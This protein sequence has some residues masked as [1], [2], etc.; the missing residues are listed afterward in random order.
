MVAAKKIIEENRQKK[1][2][3]MEEKI[4]TKKKT[5]EE[6]NKI[7]NEIKKNHT[8]NK[9]SIEISSQQD[10]NGNVQHIKAARRNNNEK[11]QDE[12]QI[13]N[14]IKNNSILIY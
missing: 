5:E 10:M 8:K 3:E 2:K 1:N 6:K 11:L 7:M 4:Q 13:F 9:D 14:S 12:I